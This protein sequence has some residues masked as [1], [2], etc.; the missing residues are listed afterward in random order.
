MQGITLTFGLTEK[1]IAQVLEIA[2]LCEL[3]TW[4]AADYAFEI[5]RKDTIALGIFESERL[6]GFIVGRRVPGAGGANSRDAEI[7]NIGVRPEY[8]RQGAGSALINDFIRC[9]VGHCVE[10]IWLDVRARNIRA[11][12][13]YNKFAFKQI[14]CRKDY[15]SSPLDDAVVMMAD[16]RSAVLTFP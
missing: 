10:S 1:D 9:C 3:S 5:Q 14:Y 4:S 11:I 16:V 6:T 2:N 15:Y 13:F 8:H 7:Y 12:T